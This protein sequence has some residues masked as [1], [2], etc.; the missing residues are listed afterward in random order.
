MNAL[1]AVAAA[2]ASVVSAQNAN[3][4]LVT[5]QNGTVR[6]E[7]CSSTSVNSFR[8]I[9]YA[10]AP[11]GE[12]RFAPPQPWQQSFNG[13]LDATKA[14]PACPQ[15]N[16]MF[17]EGVG[18]ENCLF[19]NVWAPANAT[20]S[21]KL[22]VKVW[23]YGGANE[24]GGISNALYDGCSASTNSVLVSINYRVGPLGFLAYEPLGL[25]GNYGVQDQMLALSW[26]Q[27]NIGAFGGD[28]TKVMLFGQ[29]A[30]ADDT[31]V[32]SSLPQAK[33]LMHSAALESG[34]YFPL[35]SIS[36][37]T[38]AMD[39]FVKLL[40]CS[41]VDLSCLRSTDMNTMVGA[42]Q[43]AFS[44]VTVPVSLGPVLDG[45]VISNQP[46]GPIVPFIVGSNG[47]DGSLLVAAKYLNDIL[48]LDQSSYDAFLSSR[49]SP[50]SASLVNQ[51]YPISKSFTS[52]PSFSAMSAVTT[53]YNFRCPARRLLASAET[54]GVQAWTYSFNHTPS[55]AWN[56]AVPKTPGAPN[57]LGATNTAEIPFIFG[58]VD[59]LPRPDGNCNLSKREKRLSALMLGAWDS[60]AAQASPGDKWSAFTANNPVGLSVDGDDFSFPSIDYNECDFWDKIAEAE[61]ATI[62]TTNST[63]PAPTSTTS[64]APSSTSSTSD[65]G[66]LLLEKATLYG[67][68]FVW[69]ASRLL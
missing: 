53:M 49:F 13:T 1:L 39:P 26:I 52:F 28:H 4:P 56:K 54:R 27:E 24:A 42:F 30:G 45:I 51:T 50:E 29:S 10:E 2:A 37:E 61:H 65:A 43:G 14:A 38:K 44:N 11:V 5:I 33:S 66:Q 9:P 8:S 68:G 18:S 25:T 62:T 36:E 60:M 41:T 69:V 67:A 47:N 58:Q 22:P 15:F 3:T 32:I 40:N 7:S 59:S 55:C 34:S 31:W 35:P 46:K 63:A 57:L 48:K 64:S 20:T 16:S 23:L 12:L 19:L 21:S 6:G 17:A